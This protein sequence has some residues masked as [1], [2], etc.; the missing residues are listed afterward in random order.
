MNCP[1]CA[2]PLQSHQTATALLQGCLACGG[3]FVDREAR[4]RM[5]A[6]AD[7]GV[8]EASDLAAAHARWAPDTTARIACPSCR[9][10]MTVTRLAAGGVDIDVCDAHGAWFDRNELRKF[11]DALLAQRSAAPNK[12]LGA[13]QHK[14]AAAPA[15]V[16]KR[17]SHAP[18]SSSSGTDAVEAVGG[19]L[20]IVGAI[21]Q[22]IGE[23]A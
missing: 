9:G 23:L 7:A 13:K 6:S 16:P 3:I 11:L 20:E 12:K 4:M 8:A 17:E 2:T 5:I 14:R 15:P 18:A 1:R 22:I 10:A 19:V 21:F